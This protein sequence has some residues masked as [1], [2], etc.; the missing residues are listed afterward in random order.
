[1]EGLP[2]ESNQLWPVDLT[3]ISISDY[4]VYWVTSVVGYYSRYLLTC[5]FSRTPTAQEVIEPLE[6]ALGEARQLRGLESSLR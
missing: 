1:M 6:R 4:G 2:T 5:H 3:Q